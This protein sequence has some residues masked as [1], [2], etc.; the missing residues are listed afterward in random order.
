MLGDCTQIW[1]I[2][3]S[4]LTLQQLSVKCGGSVDSMLQI[5]LLCECVYEHMAASSHTYSSLCHLWACVFWTFSNGTNSTSLDVTLFC[6]KAWF[7]LIIS[8]DL[9]CGLHNTA[10]RQWT[11]IYILI[12]QW[13][14]KLSHSFLIMEEMHFDISF[15]MHGF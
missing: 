8:L 6:P 5:I 2:E 3:S 9:L 12:A 13:F 11:L 14:V 7:V 15:F 1:T 4:H 10:D